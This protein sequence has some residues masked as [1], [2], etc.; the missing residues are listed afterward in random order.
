MNEYKLYQC[1]QCGFEYD[2]AEGWPDEGIAP[3]TRWGDIPDDWRCPDCGAAKE[4]FF[5]VEVERS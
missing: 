2:E 1:A 5:M 3:G 4:D